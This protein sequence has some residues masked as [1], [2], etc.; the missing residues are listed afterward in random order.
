MA[1]TVVGHSLHAIEAK[2]MRI[3][4]VN[5]DS[6]QIAWMHIAMGHFVNFITPIWPRR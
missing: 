4:T 6:S 1:L 3:A 2:A 5:D